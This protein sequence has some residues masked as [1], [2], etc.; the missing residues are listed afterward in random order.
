MNN[1]SYWSGLLAGGIMGA[2]VG[3][4][5]ASRSQPQRKLLLQSGEMGAR[6]RKVWH[7]LSRSMGDMLRRS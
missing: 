3:L 5:L 4:L 2:F 1:R 7:G 6:A